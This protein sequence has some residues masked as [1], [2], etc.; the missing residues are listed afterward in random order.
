MV[1]GLL[2]KDLVFKAVRL[3]PVADDKALVV[4]RALVHELAEHLKGREHARL[5]VVDAL[6]VVEDVLAQDEHEVDVGAEVGRDAERLL[7]R[8]HRHDVNVTAVHEHVAR[9]LLR[10]PRVV[11]E[12]VVKDEKGPGVHG[13]VPAMRILVTV[14]RHLHLE[15]T[16]D[17]GKNN[18]GGL[19]VVNEARG[20]HVLEELVGH[21]CAGN[22]SAHWEAVLGMKENVAHE[23][24]LARVLLTNN[25]NHRRLARV[26]LAP[27]LDDLDVELPQRKVRH[28]FAITLYIIHGQ[29]TAHEPSCAPGRTP[30]GPLVRR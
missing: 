14:P 26:N 24:G 10:N 16:L 2:P 22:D 28:S 5:I 15:L 21:L 30:H 9:A 7:H 6:A 19:L 18:L 23:E 11:V 29:R 1:A 20:D 27:L 8:N 3:N 4:F 25:D 13:G 17:G 12:T